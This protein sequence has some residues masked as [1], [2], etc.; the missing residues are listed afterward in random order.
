M[1][2]P[3]LQRKLGE[4][5]SA[6]RRAR[7]W[8]RL[9][10]CWLAAAAFCVLL[11]LFHEFTGW[12]SRLIWALPLA[13]GVVAAL[14]V[15]IAERGR[16][17]D[18][19]ALV[20]ALERTHPELRHLLSA[21]AEQQPDPDSGDFHF[22]QRRAINAVLTHRRQHLWGENIRR[23]SFS[24]FALQTG[25]LIV[26]AV[27]LLISRAFI[28]GRPTSMPRLA[29][30]G[31]K[32]TVSPG[33]TNV[34]RGIGLVISAKF[35]G[36]PP[37]EAALVLVTASGKTK[38]IPLERHLADPIFGA[39]LP[40]VTE[41]GLYHVEYSNQKTRDYKISVFDYPALTRANASLQFPAYTG[42]TNKIIPDTL[43]LSAVEGTRLTYTL[44][45]NKPVVRARLIP[46]N[47]NASLPLTVQTN[48]LATLNEF[49]LTN[50]AR[51]FLELVDAEGRT[52]KSPAEFSLQVLTNRRSEVKVAFPRGDQRVSPLEE[53]QLRAEAMD[54]FGVLK[55]GV[56]FGI[57]GQE[58]Q[59]VELG[60]PARANEKRQFTQLI[61]MEKLG[62]N[63]GQL[64]S[65]FAWADDYGPDGRVR[66]TFSDMFFAEVRPFE[67]IF[68]PDQSG[69]ESGG[70]VQGQ[71]G[72][73][74]TKL[75]EL[76][77]QIVI[78]TWKLQRDKNGPQNEVRQP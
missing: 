3:R 61:A 16:P 60:G 38:R 31:T 63:V 22:L 52:N 29:W 32:V 40:E 23:K 58:P 72:N 64:V 6:L 57:A 24:A 9:A 56:G 70:Q 15:W 26:L 41:E 10:L 21:A 36:R 34:E 51:Y 37:A 14:M 44:E 7:L 42:L 13:A 28:G 25:A 30:L 4:L 8:R 43:R 46:K 5:E 66:R 53:L 65:Y 39:S 12:N 76:Q 71:G 45:L 18:F 78:A 48:A 73:Q 69:A 20:S 67:E 27:V 35:D 68:R 62:V 59:F 77:K 33:D 47:G 2:E 19:P 11:V 55:Y 75:A 17:A 1:M 54:D 50:S 49:P 74:A